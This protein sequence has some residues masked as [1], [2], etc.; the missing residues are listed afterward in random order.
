MRGCL[1]KDVAHSFICSV[2]CLF[3]AR[4]VVEHAFCYDEDVF[5]EVEGGGDYKEGKDEEEHG[6]YVWCQS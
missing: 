4:K 1:R 5:G 3:V 6:V 2:Q